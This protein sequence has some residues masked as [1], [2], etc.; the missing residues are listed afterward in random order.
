MQT[1]ELWP[2]RLAKRAEALNW[3]Y[4]HI[5]IHF[6]RRVDQI[7]AWAGSKDMADV[8]WNV[9]LCVCSGLIFGALGNGLERA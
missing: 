8:C 2:L 4:T 6:A 9:F 5:F 1:A 7:G 3:P